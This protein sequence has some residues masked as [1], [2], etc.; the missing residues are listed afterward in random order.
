MNKP[1]LV[2]G[3]ELTNQIIALA[4]RVHSRLGPGLQ[5]HGLQEHAYERCLCHEFER[6]AVPCARQVKLP[7]E[8]DGFHLDCGYRADII[9][10]DEIIFEIKSIDRF[11]SLHKAQQL[12]YLRTSRHRIGLLMNF[13]TI[14]LKDGLQRCVL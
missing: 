9:V 3:S 10:A 8:Y 13:N 7:I 6:N 12:T 4:M 11:L 2:H 14:S 5:E 1:G